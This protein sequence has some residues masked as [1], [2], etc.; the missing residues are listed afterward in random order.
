MYKKFFGFNRSPFELSPDPHFLFATEKI[1]ETLFSICYAIAQRKGYVVLTGEVGTGKT[2]MT[3]CLLDLLKW[4]QVKFSNIFN[5]RLSP[6]DFLHFVVRDLGIEVTEPTTANLLHELYKFL[7]AEAEKGLTT[8][9]VIDE[10]Q[11]LSMDV[12][13]EVRLL[14]NLETTQQKLLQIILVGQ[15][16]LD[17]KLDSYELRQLKQRISI[18]CRLEPLNENDIRVY[19]ERRLKLAGGDEVLSIFP[20]QTVSAIFRYSFGFPRVVNSL[21]DQG[22]LVAY[23]L[24]SKTV[25]VEMIDE[26]AKYLRLQPTPSLVEQERPRT[27]VVGGQ[28]VAGK[29]LHQMV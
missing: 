10:A 16:E 25:S 17:A 12:L 6:Y 1:K 23:A 9:L 7:L 21:C 26:I 28:Q 18:R 3:R 15:P 13:E 4:Q 5:P 14:T 8:V 29:S 20:P 22:L 27:A 24:R 19:I 11:Q 2:L